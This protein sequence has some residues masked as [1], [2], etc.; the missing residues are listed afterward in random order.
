M[1]EIGVTRLLES[2]P[3]ISH[4]LIKVFTGD[5]H[6]ASDFLALWKNYIY[7]AEEI[8]IANMEHVELFQSTN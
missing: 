7:I 4:L 6:Q 3:N 5:L 2:I 8:S 1:V